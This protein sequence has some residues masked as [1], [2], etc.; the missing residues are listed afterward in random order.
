MEA[1]WLR[2]FFSCFCSLSDVES[3]LGLLDQMQTKMKQGPGGVGGS[4]DPRLAAQVNDEINTLL[5][6]LTSPMFQRIC[7]IKVG[8]FYFRRS[9]L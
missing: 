2:L 1:Q 8:E 4:D 9:L 7:K 6:V 3:V 5:S